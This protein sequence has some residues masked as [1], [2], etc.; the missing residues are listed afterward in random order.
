MALKKY[1]VLL[2][3]DNPGDARLIQ[4]MLR[5]KQGY[6]FQF[7]HVKTLEGAS[8]VLSRGEPDVVLLDLSLPDSQGL[9]T[10]NGVLDE[11]PEAAVV[12]LT[13]LKDEETGLEAVR[14]GAQ[15]FLMKDQVNG[16][17]LARAIGYAVERAQLEKRL[18]RT[19]HRIQSEFDVIAKLQ[20]D[21]LPPSLPD[22]SHLQISAHYHPSEVAGGDYYDFFDPWE[23][24]CA[25]LL[26]DVSGHGVHAAVIMAMTRVIV[27]NL[28]QMQDPGHVLDAIN[29]DLHSNIPAAHFVAC[30]YGVMDM[31]SMKFTFSVAGHQP[32][33]F[34]PAATGEGRHLGGDPQ[35]P[36]GLRRNSNYVSRTVELRPGDAVLL[37]TDGVVDAENAEGESFGFERMKKVVEE[38]AGRGSDAVK[39][40]LANALEGHMGDNIPSDDV[41][42]LAISVTDDDVSPDG[43][44]SSAM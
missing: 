40:N 21:L 22:V 43:D 36:L 10:L 15:D 4:E 23:N 28:A 37:H 29:R 13:G 34:V 16:E 12:V 19:V 31:E 27:H 8:E 18:K 9:S 42:F 6:D 38:H 5:D 17:L 35:M 3:E 39:S 7:E 32:P 33:F 41:T 25:V 26:A 11:D 24:K 14:R 2:V 30:C 44:G 20:S 1:N